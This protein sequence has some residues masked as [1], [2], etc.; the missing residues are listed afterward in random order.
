MHHN[1]IVVASG[2]IALL[3]SGCLTPSGSKTRPDPKQ[4]L[5]LKIQNFQALEQAIKT[6]AI[7]AGM[8]TEQIRESYGEPDDIFSSGSTM[9]EFEIWAYERITAKSADVFRPVRLYFN[10]NKLVSWHY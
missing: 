3:V 6:G 10:N 8:T 5:E 4:V 9:G 7:Q 2:M 1:A